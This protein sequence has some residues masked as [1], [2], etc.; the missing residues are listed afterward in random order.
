MS[1]EAFHEKVKENE[2]VEWE[3]VYESQ[4][5]GTLKSE[6]ERIWENKKYVIFDVEVNG[7]TNIKK[8]F[9][10]QAFVV[11]IRPPSFEA[12]VRRL[13]DRNTE[14]PASLKKRIRRIKRELSFESSFDY[15]LVNDVLEVALKEA[16]VVTESFILGKL[17]S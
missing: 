8:I 5:Y 16:E 13:K 12:L 7:A 9:G 3:E 2:F 15:V 4:Y 1:T 6:V 17:S 10:D 11:F 14:T